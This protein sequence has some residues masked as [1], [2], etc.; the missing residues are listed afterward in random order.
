MPD[1]SEKCLA[2]ENAFLN[3]EAP[4]NRL[5]FLSR[6]SH[7]SR[8]LGPRIWPYIT[9]RML[10]LALDLRDSSFLVCFELR[11]AVRFLGALS[12][13][14][15]QSL[16]ILPD[17]THTIDFLH[18]HVKR[19]FK[20]LSWAGIIASSRRNYPKSVMV[21]DLLDLEE[22]HAK[23]QRAQRIHTKAV[24]AFFASWREPFNL[25]TTSLTSIQLP[26]KKY[27]YPDR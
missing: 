14:F 20:K 24:L 5:A 17:G 23:A 25:S 15:E 6:S 21:N 19:F 1:T 22:H 9:D 11:F 27:Y 18:H 3:R 12:P 2:R 16:I 13:P 8:L 10:A 26:D 7:F 4:S